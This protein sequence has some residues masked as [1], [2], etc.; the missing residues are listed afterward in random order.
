MGV[1]YRYDKDTNEKVVR[2]DTDYT[3]GRATNLDNLDQAITTT[4]SNIMGGGGLGSNLSAIYDYTSTINGNLTQVVGIVEGLEQNVGASADAA[5]E[6][7]SDPSK[8]IFARLRYIYN[9]LLYEGGV[10]M[11]AAVASI[12]GLSDRSNTE[13]YDLVNAASNPFRLTSYTTKSGSAVSYIDLT[14][15][16]IYSSGALS[17]DTEITGINITNSGPLTGDVFRITLA[18]GSTKVF[19]YGASNSIGSLPAKLQEFQFPVRIPSD[20]QYKV[21]V[22]CTTAAART[23]TLTELDVIEVG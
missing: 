20:Q 4:Q 7:M 18:D 14:W 23:A 12:K 11:A 16:D 13:V 8:S 9:T 5:S 3:T 15:V 21:Q 10:S 17:K 22:Y 2:I 19:P 1:E 6:S